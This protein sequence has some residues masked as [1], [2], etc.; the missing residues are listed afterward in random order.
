[1][2]VPRFFLILTKSFASSSALSCSAAE[3]G[4]A[5]RRKLV[6]TEVFRNSLSQYG[7]LAL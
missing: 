2:N 1:M 6:D 5:K 4:A 3:S 7:K